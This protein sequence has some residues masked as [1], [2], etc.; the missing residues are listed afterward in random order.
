MEKGL[1]REVKQVQQVL[2]V[3]I[4]CRVSGRDSSLLRWIYGHVLMA[5]L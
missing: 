1:L 4:E 5:V 3:L 2:M